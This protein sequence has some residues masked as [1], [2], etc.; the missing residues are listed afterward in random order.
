MNL[1]ELSTLL[2]PVAGA[3]GAAFAVHE[4][5]PANAAWLWAVIPLG[6]AFGIG[7][8]RALMRLAVLGAE[9]EQQL[10]S[11]RAAALL[12]T[13]MFAPY[14]AAALSFNL[15]RVVIFVAA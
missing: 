13:G 12:A 5:I 2:S 15:V 10:S 4:Y 7:C 1:F 3:T 14:V 11:W 9:R 8:Y 6:L